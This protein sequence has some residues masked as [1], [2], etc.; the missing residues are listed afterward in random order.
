MLLVSIQDLGL[1]WYRLAAKRVLGCVE[2]YGGAEL[3]SRLL[4]Y[5]CSSCVNQGHSSSRALQRRHNPYPCKLSPDLHTGRNAEV[6]M[7]WWPRH[8]YCHSRFG[9][10]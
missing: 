3:G 10:Y 4:C 2:K 9:T 7:T 1:Q 6:H 8:K 5:C